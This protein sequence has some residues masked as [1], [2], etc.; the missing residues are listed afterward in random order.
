VEFL[1]PTVFSRNGR[2]YPL[3]DPVLAL[4]G[5]HQRWTARAD[6][7]APAGSR[8]AGPEAGGVDGALGS[9]VVEHLDGHTQLVEAP[10]RRIGFTGSATFALRGRSSP[11]ADQAFAAL[12]A[13]AAL[14]GVGR[15]TTYGLGAVE[16]AHE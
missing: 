11:A 12:W 1:T 13:F 14:A 6:P 3:P 4:R 7:A 15:S 2:D 5:L 16:V 9:V 8:H 10:T